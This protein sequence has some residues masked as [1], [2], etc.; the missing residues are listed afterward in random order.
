[1]RTVSAISEFR[2]EKISILIGLKLETQYEFYDIK[3]KK[4]AIEIEGENMVFYEGPF[5]KDAP[6][7][8]KFNKALATYLTEQDEKTKNAE[9]GCIS[10]LLSQG[11]SEKTIHE[12]IEFIKKYK[13]NAIIPKQIARY[14]TKNINAILKRMEARKLRGENM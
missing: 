5:I 10:V 4:L 12:C 13:V 8:D 6:I 1:M 7:T 9:A 2:N 14:L 3:N 11:H